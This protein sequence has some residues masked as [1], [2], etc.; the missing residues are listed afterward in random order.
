[1]PFTPYKVSPTGFTPVKP[2]NEPEKFPSEA[3]TEVKQS[4]L[5]RLQ[6]SLGERAQNVEGIMQRQE[7]GKQGLASSALQFAGQGAAGVFDVVGDVAQPITSRIGQTKIGQAAKSVAGTVAQT[8][9]VQNT[10]QKYDQWKKAN[11]EAAY[12]LE[13]VVNIGSLVPGAKTGQAGLKTAGKVAG[14]T[15]GVLEK[16]AIKSEAKSL[17]KFAGEL[18]KPIQ[19]K[20][21]KESQVSRT[22]ETGRG[23]L[24]RSVVQPTTQEVRSAE[25]ISRVPGI[26]SSKTMQQN[27]NAVQTHNRTLAQGLDE[28]IAKRGFLVPRKESVAKLR[29]AAKELESSPT[30]VG[31]AEKTAQKLI[32]GM[33]KFL[34]EEPGTGQGVLNARKKYDEWV[35]SQKPKAF[36]AAS[37][38]AFT[39]ANREIRQA[40]NDLLE[41]KAPDLEVKKSLAEQ[42]SLYRAMDT[43]APKAA[44][45]AD[46]AIGRAMQSVGR[47]LGVKN[48]AV[49][50]AAAVVGVGGLG[51]AA[52]FAP[53]I[54]AV[55]V[56]MFL[57]YKGGQLAMKPGVR[58][59]LSKVL[60]ETERALKATTD[61]IEVK[62]LEEAK[63][64]LKKSLSNY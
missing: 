48:R 45:E 6:G 63:N 2:L 9:P 56:P 7:S 58:N 35:R 49:Q 44:Q 27:Y 8:K 51:A 25:A 39:T 47:V 1:M 43:I 12:N 29:Q 54:A 18:V 32:Q 31:D 33:E 22:T 52:T 46:S 14:K 37:E 41:A 16:S 13:A 5:Q 53:G 42:S 20:A 59:A 3:P 10:I 24:K 36:D 57:A 28:S 64:A 30:I 40:M 23:I 61:P 11:P 34:N 55:G 17:Q 38:N 62:A 50:A 26:N 21:I 60:H 4:L 19:T 15:A